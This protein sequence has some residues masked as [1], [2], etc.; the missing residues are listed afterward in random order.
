[1]KMMKTGKI[2]K[3]I[4]IIYIYNV[5]LDLLVYYIIYCIG[6]HRHSSVRI[7]AS[8]ASVSVLIIH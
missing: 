4:N 7:I 3:R 2:V 8:P 5:S 1:M 6:R